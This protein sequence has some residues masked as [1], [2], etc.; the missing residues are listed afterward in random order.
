MQNVIVTRVQPY[1]DEGED[2]SVF[3]QCG[4]TE[5]VVFH[6]RGE[7]RVGDIL[8]SPLFAALDYEVRAAYLEDWPAELRAELCRERIERTSWPFGYRGVGHVID[9]SL[10]LVNVLGFTIDF[11]DLSHLPSGT[12]VEFECD[13][14][15][16]G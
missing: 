8:R 16:M 11:G 10:A 4:N 14:L 5:L 6:A 15:D 9:S 12:A 13:R 7:V 2:A 3:V 1:S